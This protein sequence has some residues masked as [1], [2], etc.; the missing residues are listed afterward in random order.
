MKFESKINEANTTQCKINVF[1]EYLNY[2]YISYIVQTYAKKH[3]II[4]HETL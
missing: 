4:K 2:S 3:A 1:T